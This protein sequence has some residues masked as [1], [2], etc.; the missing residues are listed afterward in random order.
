MLRQRQQQ[1][2]PLRAHLRSGEIA[3][4]TDDGERLR[5]VFSSRHHERQPL[6]DRFGGFGIREELVGERFR[7]DGHHL[8]A[9]AVIDA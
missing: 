4:D 2:F 8:G 3:G 9:R 6:A 7:D 5:A 1:L